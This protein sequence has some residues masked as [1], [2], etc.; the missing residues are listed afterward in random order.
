MQTAASIS[1]KASWSS[2]RGLPAAASLHSFLAAR[3]NSEMRISDSHG[4]LKL[5]LSMNAYDYEFITI[6]G[7]KSRAATQDAASVT[8]T[9]APGLPFQITP[10]DDLK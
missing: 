5:T 6:P 10:S 9:L 4:I 2:S 3:P 8:E 1:T 7:S